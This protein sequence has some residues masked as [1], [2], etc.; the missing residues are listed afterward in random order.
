MSEVEYS[1]NGDLTYTV[2]FNN[3]IIGKVDPLGEDIRQVYIYEKGKYI[4]NHTFLSPEDA[5]SYFCTLVGA[6]NE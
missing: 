2:W 5:Y 1:V 4:L 3:K 6:S